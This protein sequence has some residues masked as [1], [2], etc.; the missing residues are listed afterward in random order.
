ME[1]CIFCEAQL[2]EEETDKGM[3]QQCEYELVEAGELVP[4]GKVAYA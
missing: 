2:S 3:C 4:V 1:S